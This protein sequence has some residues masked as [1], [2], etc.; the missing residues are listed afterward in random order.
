MGA[1]GASSNVRAVVAPLTPCVYAPL[2]R[3]LAR[4]R[5]FWEPLYG[6][7]R[8]ERAHLCDPR[9]AGTLAKTRCMK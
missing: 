7:N 1:W 3:Y 4:T 2:R 6:N 9:G 8:M 5:A